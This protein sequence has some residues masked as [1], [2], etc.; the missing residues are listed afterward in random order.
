MKKSITI[1]LTLTIWLGFIDSA[2]ASEEDKDNI[3][4]PFSD[5]SLSES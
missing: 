1:L 5:N 3:I 2:Y 4:V